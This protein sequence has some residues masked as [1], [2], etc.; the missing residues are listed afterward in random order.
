MT[1]E[2]SPSSRCFALVPCAGSGSRASTGA[3]GRLP[4]QYATIDGQAMVS[5][6]L[7]A[8][9]GVQRLVSV[10]VVTAPGDE[11]FAQHVAMPVGMR[12][13]VAACGGETRA[14]SVAAGLEVLLTLGAGTQDWVLV[15]D[16]ARCLVRPAWIDAL[17][18]DCLDD[19]VGGLLALPVADTLKHADGDRV[20]ATL[21]RAHV[22]QAQT[23][24]MFRLGLLAEALRRFGAEATDD[25]SAVEAMGLSPR[26]V[27]GAAEN[28]KV[29]HQA[30]VALAEAIL[31]GRRR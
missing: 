15:H 1:A 23:P 27:H 22:W 26:L 14:L 11:A 10:L 6:T 29:T 4:K 21:S 18:D 16:A 2:S 19:P 24:Q 13:D 5:H 31:R 12:V 28:L 30:D 3:P 7:A 8:L 9:A 17:I 20:D 25:A